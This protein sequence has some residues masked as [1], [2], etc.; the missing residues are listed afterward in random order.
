M[1]RYMQNEL[2]GAGTYAQVYKG[3]DMESGD[4]V[5]LKKTKI[6]PKEGMP[7]TT[8]RE[9]SILKSVSHQNIIKIIEVIHQEDYVTIVFEFIEYDLMKYIVH[10]GNVLYLINQL[11]SGIHH[12]HSQNVVHRDLKPHNILVTREGILKIADFGLARVLHSTDFTYS[13]EVITLWYR[14]P[15]LLMGQ[16]QY[17]CA[18]DI[19]SLGCIIYEMICRKPLMAGQDKESQLKLISR[20]NVM[21]VDKELKSVYGTP[22][23]ISFI[24]CKCLEADHDKRITADEIVLLLEQAYDQI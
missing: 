20:L 8:M 1:T 13:P 23:I 11:I 3:V 19:W 10:E 2:I 9:I 4:I 12:L 17:G 15:E 5:A 7:S 14:P 22:K 18:V 24:V 21:E 6:N 16:T